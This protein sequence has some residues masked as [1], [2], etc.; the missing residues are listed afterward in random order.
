[1]VA[2]KWKT[3]RHTRTNAAGRGADFSNF[4]GNVGGVAEVKSETCPVTFFASGLSDSEL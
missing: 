4:D 3:R 1:M 2:L